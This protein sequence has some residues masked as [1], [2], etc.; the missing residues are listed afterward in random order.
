MN[1]FAPIRA[2]AS[3]DR[4]V[5]RPWC[6]AL[7]VLLLVATGMLAHAQEP[8][9]PQLDRL[10]TSAE[11]GD[12]AA[13]L[14]LGL[15]YY[16]GNG[17]KYPPDY[18]EA[19]LWFHRAADQRNPE[20]QDRIGMMYYQG[21]GVPQDY[22]EAAR[23]YLLAAQSGNDH[24][25]RQLIEMYSRGLG[26]PRDLRESKKWATEQ[27]AHHP[28]KTA[29]TVRVLFGV[30]CLA[31]LAFSVGL[32]ALQRHALHG[33][34]RLAVGIF[35]HAAGIALV[36]NSLTTY[37]FGLV[38]PHCSHNFLATAC[39]Q[40]SDPHTRKIVNEIGD[41]AMVNLLF[42]FMAGIGLVLDILAAW[43]LVYL[44]QLLFRRSPRPARLDVLPNVQAGRTR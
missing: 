10:T 41:W 23:W 34:K 16:N 33:W 2:S 26:V 22:A 27:N 42:R 4:I 31:V 21:K 39:T 7:L 5:G 15:H 24:A 30:G 17:R 20:A 6:V 35:V 29:T 44:C 13:Q 11:Q 43:Y 8:V 19:L 14:Q 1:P 32:A 38:F 18:A 12:V 37:G 28:D 3:I 9:D 40:I 25:Q 36:L